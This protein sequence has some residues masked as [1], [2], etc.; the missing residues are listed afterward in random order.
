LRRRRIIDLGDGVTSIALSGDPA[1]RRR[2]PAQLAAPAQTIEPGQRDDRPTAGTSLLNEL[3]RAIQEQ[4]ATL[5]PELID[6]KLRAGIALFGD[7]KTRQAQAI[8]GTKTRDNT[9]QPL[10][11]TSAVQHLLDQLCALT[12][13]DGLTGLFNRR[14]FDQR[15]AYELG[16]VRRDYSP[17]S[18][19]MIDIDHFKNVND[20]YGHDVGDVVLRHVAQVLAQTLRQTDIVCRFGGEEFVVILPVTSIRE[21]LRA[22]ERLRLAIKRSSVTVVGQTISVSVSA[23]VAF[24]SPQ[25]QIEQDELIRRADQALYRAKADGRDCTR[26]YGTLEE[27]H[28]ARVSAAEKEA[29]F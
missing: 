15:L 1:N 21:A 6:A 26:P 10:I 17:C 13:S 7:L 23:G 5:T 3:Q 29:L 16:R 25:E 20:R 18:L 27:P 22:A 8:L 19:I 2:A 11:R 14:H 12:M 4:D 28:P 9:D 24:C